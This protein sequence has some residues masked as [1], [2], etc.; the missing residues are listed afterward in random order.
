M[1]KEWLPFVGGNG[2]SRGLV[3]AFCR[4]R[5]VKKWRSDL[6]F[7]LFGGEFV[8]RKGRALE[9]VLNSFE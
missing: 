5:G 4:R 9:S 8:W 6:K 7:G 1:R 3:E 2:S